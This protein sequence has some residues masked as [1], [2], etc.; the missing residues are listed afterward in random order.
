MIGETPARLKAE[1]RSAIGPQRQIWRFAKIDNH[2]AATRWIDKRKFAPR[3]IDEFKNDRAGQVLT[4]ERHF[5]AAKMD[6][7]RFAGKKV[8]RRKMAA[9][10][11]ARHLETKRF[12]RC[13]GE[14]GMQPKRHMRLEL[15]FVILKFERDRKS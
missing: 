15:R 3:H 5:A 13:R 14:T 4:R 11:T 10:K 8:T 6:L 12:E 2:P 1:K 7:A 9:I